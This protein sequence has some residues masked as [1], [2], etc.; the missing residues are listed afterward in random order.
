MTVLSPNKGFL[1]SYFLEKKKSQSED[2]EWAQRIYLAKWKYTPE[3]MECSIPRERQSGISHMAAF[4]ISS[5]N[6]PPLVLCTWGDYHIFRYDL[7]YVYW[8]HHVGKIS[9]WYQSKN[10]G[11]GSVQSA[12]WLILLQGTQSHLEGSQCSGHDP[13]L[14]RSLSRLHWVLSGFKKVVSAYPGEG[15][16]VVYGSPEVEWSSCLQIEL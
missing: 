4:H 5:G 16:W 13:E 8:F 7:V 14:E 11:R 1:A 3:N 9:H 15:L 12:T 2:T 10:D 6:L